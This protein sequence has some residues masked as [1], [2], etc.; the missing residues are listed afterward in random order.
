MRSNTD[1]DRTNSKRV[2]E[3]IDNYFDHGETSGKE[4]GKMEMDVVQI[5]RSEMAGIEVKGRKANDAGTDSMR[6]SSMMISIVNM[7]MEQ[8]LKKRKRMGVISMEMADGKGTD[9]DVD[10]RDR[11]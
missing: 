1:L 10:G 11:R 7:S 9:G 5:A 4:I 8:R 2:T 3:I 6:R